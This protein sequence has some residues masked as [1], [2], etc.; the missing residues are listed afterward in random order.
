MAP[1]A[2]KAAFVLV[3]PAV[4]LFKEPA[5]WILSILRGYVTLT[6]LK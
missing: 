1:I 6:I 4:F 5:A 2:K 3:S